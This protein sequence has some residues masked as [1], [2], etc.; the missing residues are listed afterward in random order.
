M[1]EWKSRGNGYHI[2]RVGYSVYELWHIGS[3]VW[4]WSCRTR[5]GYSTKTSQEADD[6]RTLEDVRAAALR[7]LK[8]NVEAG[9]TA[10]GGTVTWLDAE[11][12]ES[13]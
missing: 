12:G 8:Q 7:H 10:L 11:E 3:D 2:A 6:G 1:I 9:V 4:T 5:E 13:Q